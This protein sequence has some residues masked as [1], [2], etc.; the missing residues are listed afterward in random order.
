MLCACQSLTGC[1]T[2]AD[3]ARLLVL[4]RCSYREALQ[5]WRQRC[6]A[7]ETHG[8]TGY[9]TGK[10]GRKGQADSVQVQDAQQVGRACVA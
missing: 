10:T 9:F 5:L 6:L 4:D 2:P 1:P 7:M 3:D 8:R